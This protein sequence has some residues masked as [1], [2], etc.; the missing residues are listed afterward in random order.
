MKRRIAEFRSRLP[1]RY[2]PRLLTQVTETS[3][4]QDALRS[5]LVVVQDDS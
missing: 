3:D 4:L 5:T 2:E 1:D